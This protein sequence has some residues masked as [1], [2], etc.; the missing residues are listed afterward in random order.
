MTPIPRLPHS[1]LPHILAAL[2]TAAIVFASLQPFGPWLAPPAG[3]PF[4]ALSPDVRST[5]FDW[6]LNIVAYAPLGLFAALVPRRAH[7]VRRI[8]TGAVAGFVLSFA[9]ETAQAYL[10]TRDASLLD[11]ITNTLGAAGGGALAARFARSPRLKR[12]IT[13]ARNRWFIGGKLGDAALALLALWLVAQS[14]P[15]IG[16][17]AISW[18]P[19]AALGATPPRDVAAFLVDAF[20]SALQTLGMGLFIALMVRE[21]RYLG[22]AIVALIVIATASKGGISMA[23]LRPPP[24]QSWLRPE[25]SFGIAVG[26]L[27]L[28]AFIELARPVLIVACTVAL[29]LSVAVPPIVSDTQ[30]LHVTLTLFNWRYGQLLNFNGLTHTVLLAWPL[31]ATAWLF[32]L[33]G[34][35]GWGAADAGSHAGIG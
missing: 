20:E 13:G 3:A 2:Y 18:D 32:A 14:N 21:R 7:P 33:A 6:L 1:H 9:M 29:L 28:L 27:A 15:A 31:A 12:A 23:M 8:A 10:P 5:R 4:W 26:A 11:W 22:A 25:I 35:P 30:S 34:Q 17:F 19:S 24:W 16:L